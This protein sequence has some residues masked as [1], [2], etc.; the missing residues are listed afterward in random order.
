MLHTCGCQA[1]QVF[2][3]M[4]VY[5]FCWSAFLVLTQRWEQWAGHSRQLDKQLTRYHCPM[6]C[7]VQVKKKMMILCVF[8][9][10]CQCWC[11]CQWSRHQT[12]AVYSKDLGSPLGAWML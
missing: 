3:E 1:V 6:Q 12:P 11:L 7:M 10:V 5:G 4:R 8:V 9:V 2:E